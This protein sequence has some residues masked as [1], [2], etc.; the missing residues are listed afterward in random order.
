MVITSTFRDDGGVHGLMRGCDLVPED[1]D[2]ETMEKIR[3]DT[4]KEWDYGK[5]NLQVIPPVRHGTAPHL[6]CQCRNSTRRRE[7]SH[8]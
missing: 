6:H 7:A 1:R 2:V 4:N 5:K 3:K 8:A